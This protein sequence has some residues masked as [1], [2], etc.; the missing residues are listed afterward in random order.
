MMVR[1]VAVGLAPRAVDQGQRRAD[2]AEPADHQ[3]GARVDGGHRTGGG[4]EF[5]PRWSHRR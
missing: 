5:G 2:Q 1:S 4:P 3:C